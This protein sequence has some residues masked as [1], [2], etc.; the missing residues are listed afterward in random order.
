MY[1][2]VAL[3]KKVVALV[4]RQGAQEV[5]LYGH[6]V[7]VAPV[8]ERDCSDCVRHG[9][10][11]HCCMEE[12]TVDMVT[13]AVEMLLEKPVAVGAYGESRREGR[14]EQWSRV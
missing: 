2:A 13:E 8:T 1:L 6:G 14:V 5:Y 3:G 11:G 9:G 4:G 12:I 7:K 10:L